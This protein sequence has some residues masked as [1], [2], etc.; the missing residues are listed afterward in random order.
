MM[1]KNL[2]SD[3]YKGINGHFGGCTL[4]A[5]NTGLVNFPTMYSNSQ[6]RV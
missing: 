6:I 3:P 2:P 4:Y 1:T 5:M